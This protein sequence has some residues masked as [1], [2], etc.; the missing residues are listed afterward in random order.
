MSG[1]RVVHR[2]PGVIVIPK[3]AVAKIACR[4]NY[5]ALDLALSADDIGEL[6]RTPAPTRAVAGIDRHYFFSAWRRCRRLLLE[7]SRRRRIMVSKSREPG[8]V[9]WNWL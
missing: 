8:S 1:T 2:K 7:N 5:A 3:A 9:N 6:D 4:N